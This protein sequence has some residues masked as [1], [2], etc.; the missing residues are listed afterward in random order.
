MFEN[1]IYIASVSDDKDLI[2]DGYVMDGERYLEICFLIF[3][4]SRD[5]S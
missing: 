1:A 4:S 5:S 2:I 3:I